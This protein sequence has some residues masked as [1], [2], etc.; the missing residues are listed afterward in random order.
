MENE[1]LAG[2]ESQPQIAPVI[3]SIK[4]EEKLQEKEVEKINYSKIP[5]KEIVEALEKE[6]VNVDKSKKINEV[7]KQETPIT[8]ENI[9]DKKPGIL[10]I[11]LR[12]LRSLFK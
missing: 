2:V 11:F 9:S 1:A 8:M 4:P 7:V 12:Y 5:E 10:S 3:E 6:I